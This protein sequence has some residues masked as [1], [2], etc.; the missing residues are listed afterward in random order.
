MMKL[1]VFVNDPLQAYYKKGVIKARYYNPKNLF[2]EVHMISPSDSDIAEDKVQETVGNAKLKIH[3]IGKTTFINKDRKKDKVLRLIKEIGPDVIRSYNPLLEGWLAAYCSK[4]LGIPFFLSLHIQY[5][6]LR[7]LVKLRN[8]K[9]YLALKYSRKF[10]EPYV[11]KNADKITAVYR[12]IEPYVQELGRTKPEILYNRVDLSQFQEGKKISSYDKPLILSVGRLTPQKNH[13]CLIR[14]VKN[15]DVYLLII[16]DGEQK[17]YL[18]DLVKKLGMENKIMFKSSVQNKQIQDYYKTAD[19]FALA[20]DP[21]I[22]G[23]P[24]PVLEAMAAGLPIVIS[25][26][27]SKFSDGL[28]GA[29]I[30]SNIDPQSF[31]YEIKKI[32][33]DESYAQTLSDHAL[34]KAREFDGKIMEEREA[35][36]Y[37][38]LLKTGK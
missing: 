23:V 10:I 22:E 16:G 4:K 33:A 19:L 18:I 20:Y 6:G 32:L 36:I 9:K 30:F 25:K 28:E 31:A 3:C 8:Y 29:V 37:Q 24:I 1:C 15:L 21:E 35:S 34:S 27:S 7:K 5:D 12:I 13:E 26:P 14:A 38:E 2:D 17:E 11:I